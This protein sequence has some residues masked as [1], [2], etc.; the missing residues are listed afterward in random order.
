MDDI[1][2]S[3]SSYGWYVIKEYLKNNSWWVILLIICTAIASLFDYK[4]ILLAFMIILVVVPMIMSI[5][6]F[7]Y[8]LHPLARYSILPKSMMF[9]INA[10]TIDIDIQDAEGNVTETVH[11]T[12]DDFDSLN[13]DSSFLALRYR[14]SKY[15]YLVLPL[16]SLSNDVISYMVSKYIPSVLN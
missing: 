8:V 6:Y 9:D 16:K 4:Y 12:L 1:R 3:A 13:V 7:K 15:I 2:I 11:Y 14:E 5:V 10:E